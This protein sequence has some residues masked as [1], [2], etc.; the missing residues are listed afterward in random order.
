MAI[1]QLSDEEILNELKEEKDPKK[2][3]DGKEF[4]EV[5]LCQPGTVI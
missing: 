4:S 2:D 3:N 5:T 1:K